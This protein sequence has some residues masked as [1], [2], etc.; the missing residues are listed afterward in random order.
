MSRPDGWTE[1][2]ATIGL[3]LSVVV[4][5]NLIGAAVTTIDGR[6]GTIVDRAG[7]WTSPE[8][9]GWFVVDIPG[10]GKRFYCIT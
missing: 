3:V 2:L 8:R 4:W 5:K 7:D 6:R 9:R 10:A 1:H